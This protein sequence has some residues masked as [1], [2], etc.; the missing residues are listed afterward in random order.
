MI[1]DFC[2]LGLKMKVVVSDGQNIDLVMVDEFCIGVVEIY[3]VVVELEGDNVYSLF[4][5]SM[6]CSGFSCGILL[7]D[8]IMKVVVFV[9]DEVLVFGY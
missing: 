9:M 8:S 6:D 7:V 5:Q 4:V 2:I 3:D 1:F